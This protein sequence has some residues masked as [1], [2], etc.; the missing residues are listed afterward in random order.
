LYLECADIVVSTDN[1]KPAD[2]IKVIIERLNL[3]S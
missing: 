3:A 2:V 1:Q